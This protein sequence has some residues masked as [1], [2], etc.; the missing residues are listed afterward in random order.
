MDYM[1]FLVLIV[2]KN[3]ECNKYILLYHIAVFLTV[4]RIRHVFVAP[5]VFCTTI[6]TYVYHGI[7]HVFV[8]PC[9]F[10]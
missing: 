5:C 4:I 6:D 2:A 1:F 9:F 10:S 3:P 8:A 7:R